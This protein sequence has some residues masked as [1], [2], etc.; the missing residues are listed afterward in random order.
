[1]PSP[2]AHPAAFLLAP[3]LALSA[4]ALAQQT[5]PEQNGGWYRWEGGPPKLW[6][7]SVEPKFFY[8][9]PS[10]DVKLPG[11]RS[12][13]N[14]ISLTD[15]NV[16][17]PDIAFFGEIHIRKDRW[18]VSASG[19]T[20][21]VEG[22]AFLE[23]DETFGDAVGFAGETVRTRLDFTTF[24]LLG[25][26]RFAE[27]AGSQ[28]YDGVY[29]TVAGLEVIGGVRYYDVDLE[30]D[31]DLATRD[32]IFLLPSEASG[33]RIFV[34]PVVGIRGDVEFYEQWAIEVE[35]TVGGFFAGDHSSY[36]WDI[37]AQFTW[38]P[39]EHI[40]AFVGYRQL[41]FHLEDG[42]SPGKFEWD[43]ALAGLFFGA[44]IRF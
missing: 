5:N 2:R 17:D 9:A 42:D 20:L 30:I 35:S 29:K 18:R 13:G 28:S 19:F 41:A 14:D 7:L 21:N 31:V 40:G 15:L 10:G 1:M 12:N 37:K 39:T 16:D 36:S 38:R 23:Q 4:P 6:S 3:V 26:Y 8:V 11:T 33:D 34:H 32:T 43:G 24:E 27:Y 44:Q 25:S 22:D